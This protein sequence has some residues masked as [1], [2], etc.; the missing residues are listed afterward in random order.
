M[1]PSRASLPDLAVLQAFEAAARHGNFTKAAAELNLTQSAISRQIRTLEE[2]LGVALFERA[3]QRVHLSVTG[4]QILATVQR[5]LA[6]SAA[7]GCR[8][9]RSPHSAIDG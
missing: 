7:A 1:N 2:Q 8:S 6:Q 4:R 3:R 9:R 5:L